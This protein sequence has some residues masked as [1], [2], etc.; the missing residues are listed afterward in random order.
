M[1]PQFA[2]EERKGWHVSGSLIDTINP[3][4]MGIALMFWSQVWK[5]QM[6]NVAHAKMMLNSSSI[7][8]LCFFA[9]LFACGY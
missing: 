3:Q 9:C 8:C 7:N 2:D 4:R 5:T 1:A 6:Q